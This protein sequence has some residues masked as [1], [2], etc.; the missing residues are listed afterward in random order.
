MQKG[1]AGIGIGR[2]IDSKSGVVIHPPSFAFPFVAVVVAGCFAIMLLL[3]H[4]IGCRW[5]EGAVK[6]AS[7]QTILR[8]QSQRWGHPIALTGGVRA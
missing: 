1:K 5:G 4:V 3:L 7:N 8:S 2:G 6:M